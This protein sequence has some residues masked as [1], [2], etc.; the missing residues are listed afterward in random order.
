MNYQDLILEKSWSDYPVGLSGCRTTD[1]FFDSCDYD[2]T[3][4]DEKS[5]N[6]EVIQFQNNYVKIYK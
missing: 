1:S 3:V 5:Q 2:I 4:F 6:Q